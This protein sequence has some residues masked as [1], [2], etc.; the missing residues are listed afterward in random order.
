MLPLW[1]RLEEIDD[2]RDCVREKNGEGRVERGELPASSE[3]DG[4]EAA[5]SEADG[6]CAD[7]D[8]ETAHSA[9]HAAQ[10]S[11]VDEQ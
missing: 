3:L 10:E 1:R 8:V 2:R 6:D 4:A 7:D 9:P 11:F 5:N